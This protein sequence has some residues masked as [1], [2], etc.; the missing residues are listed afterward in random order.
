M[1]ALLA[2]AASRNNDKV[3]LLLFTDHVEKYS[4]RKAAATSC[5]WCELLTFQPRGGTDLKA[6]GLPTACSSG[7][8]CFLVVRLSG[9][10]PDIPQG[11]ERPGAT[12][13]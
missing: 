3:G 8:D 12:T 7:A 5:A 1:A 6:A 10:S 2:F 9:R 13:W 11:I 4:P